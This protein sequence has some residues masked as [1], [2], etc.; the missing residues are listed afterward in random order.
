MYRQ[1]DETIQDNIRK[2]TGTMKI[3]KCTLID[4]DKQRKRQMEVALQGQIAYEYKYMYSDLDR[5]RK[6]KIEAT[7]QGQIADEDK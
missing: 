2:D 3:N 6:R 5:Q 1:K 7:L 4:S